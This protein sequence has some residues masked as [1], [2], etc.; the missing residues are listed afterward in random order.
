MHLLFLVRLSISSPRQLGSQ[1]AEVVVVH[2][3]GCWAGEEGGHDVQLSALMAGKEYARVSIKMGVTCM[4]D[5]RRN[6]KL[7]V[8]CEEWGQ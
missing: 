2:A 6:V 1:T 3:F 8:V 5:G 4:G 7:P